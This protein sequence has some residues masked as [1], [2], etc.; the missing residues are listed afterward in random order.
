MTGLLNILRDIE[1]MLTEHGLSDW[2][3]KALLPILEKCRA[4]LSM[5]VK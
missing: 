2:Q 4:V 5:L 3:K 1:R